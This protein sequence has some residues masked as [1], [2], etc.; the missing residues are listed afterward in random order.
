MQVIFNPFDGNFQFIAGSTST[1]WKAPVTTFSSLPSSGNTTGDV[2][3]TSDTGL[4]Y[5]WN[6]SLWSILNPVVPTAVAGSSSPDG[7]TVDAS[8]NLTLTPA[9]I[10]NPGLVTT[11]TQS[12]AGDKTLTGN[13][14][15]S[16]TLQVSGVSTLNA[17][18]NATSTLTVTNTTTTNG[19]LQANATIDMASTKITS[20][21]NGTSSGD[22]VNFG[23]L[24]LYIPLTQKGSANGVAALDASSKIPSS[25][26][27]STVFQ[28]EG[29]W[30][31]NTN[32]PSLVDGTGTNGFVYY[33][34]SAKSGTVAGLTDPS[35]T[36]FQLGDLV[37]YS[38]SIGKY[39]LT[40]PAAGVSSVNGAQGAVTVNAINE[41]TGDVVAGPSSGSQS[42]ISTV[43]AIMGTTVD[44]TT[45]TSN[46]VFNTNPTIGDPTITGTLN[47]SVIIASS[48]ITGSNL[49]GTNT[50]NVTLT[51][52]GGSP[53]TSAASLSGQALT[54][55]PANT[56]FPGVLLATDWNTFN[57]KQPSGSYITALTG[58]VVANGPGSVGSTIQPNSVTNAKLAQMGANTV[59]ANTTGSTANA[60]DIPLGTV[61][62]TTSAVLTLTGWTDATIGS[63]T[64]QVSQSTTSTSG[65]LSSTDW[66]TFNNKPTS[67]SGDI[68]PTSFSA[69]NNVT[70]AADVTGLAFSNATTGSFE[71]L[72][73]VL[74]NATTPLRQTYNIQGTQLGA[75]NWSM[76][77]T[78]SGN[79]SGFVFTITSSGTIQYTNNNYAGFTSATV[80]FRAITL[81]L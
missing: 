67:A 5:E 78:T 13:T 31:P 66:N 14:T 77:Q 54:L 70:S 24:S 20:L 74:V 10:T 59:K 55:Q 39:Q 21:S 32:T 56:S 3:A 34:S 64:I 81:T 50:G 33:V 8:N 76:S 75:G 4:A 73:Q 28:Y 12:L 69:A 40:T 16:G 53:N 6:G 2:R 22:A 23:Q 48:T 41:L 52:V 60:S 62:E 35:M 49:T 17:A 15:L 42:E 57:N 30:N 18:V 72:V 29:S 38:S 47:A 19:L 44:G 11:T 51:T 58:D 1:S 43:Q 61:T 7:V 80:R 26:L 71:A 68:N 37:I 46:V 63:P 65:Y 25:Q 36:N 9:D 27:P 45:G 79:E